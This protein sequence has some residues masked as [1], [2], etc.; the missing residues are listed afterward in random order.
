MEVEYQSSNPKVMSSSLTSVTMTRSLL[1]LHW[2]NLRKFPETFGKSTENSEDIGKLRKGTCIY[3]AHKQETF[4]A[5]WTVWSCGTRLYVLKITSGV[6]TVHGQATGHN[7][8]RQ[9]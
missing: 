2:V 9:Q 7:T 4:S 5:P 3:P 1:F 8:G 6:L